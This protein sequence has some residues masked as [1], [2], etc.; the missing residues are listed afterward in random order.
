MLWLLVF[1]DA[2]LCVGFNR[3]VYSDTQ[4]NIMEDRNPHICVCVSSFTCGTIL[5]LTNL[6]ETIRLKHTEYVYSGI[7]NKMQRYIIVFITIN[8]LHVSGGSSAHHQELK[9]VHTAAGI[10]QAFSASY[11]YHEWVGT[12]QFVLQFSAMET[13]YRNISYFFCVLNPPFKCYF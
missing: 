3:S 12:A 11:R 5:P 8:A 9:I 1:C 4:R 2:G 10:C 6:C 13:K 7:T